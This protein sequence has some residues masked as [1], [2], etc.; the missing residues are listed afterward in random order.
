MTIN[1][2][3]QQQRIDVQHLRKSAAWN[4]AKIIPNF[5]QNVWRWDCFGTPIK[6]GDHGDR[7]SEHG[8]EIDH[9]MP[10]S[11][12]GVD[13]HSNLQALHW[14]NNCAKSNF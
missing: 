6:W 14:R 9:V 4:R 7:D 1:I 8:W 13:E 3:P 11:K 2:G 5:D 10:L 12:G